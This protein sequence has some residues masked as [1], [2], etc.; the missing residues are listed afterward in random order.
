MMWVAEKNEQE[1][2]IFFFMDE[3][4]CWCCVWVNSCKN[5]HLSRS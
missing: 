4:G 5:P 1:D 3:N 2:M